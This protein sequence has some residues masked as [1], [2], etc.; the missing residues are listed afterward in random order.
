M[1][2]TDD[3]PLRVVH[4]GDT[5][6][7]RKQLSAATPLAVESVA[8]AQQAVERLESDSVDGVVSEYRLPDT[9]GVS[10]CRT[11]RAAFPDVPFVLFTGA[12]DERLAGEAI[13]AGVDGYVTE[14]RG[15][16]AVV[17][18]LRAALPATDRSPGESER[19]YK[20]LVDASPAPINLFDASGEILYGNDAVLDLL[21][22][23][24]TADL[25]GRSIFEFIA[26]D[27]ETT[28]R[29]ELRQ[30]V[31]E[32]RSVGPTAMR[33]VT[34]DGTERDILVST[35]PGEYG[36]EA[37]GQAVVTDVTELQEVKREL[38]A[39]RQF[40]ESALDALDDV[41]FV[42]DPDGNL[43]R[44]NAR[45]PEV[46]GHSDEELAEIQ[47]GDLLV[48]ADVSQAEESLAQVLE[49]GQDVAEVRL[50]TVE[51]AVIP[52]EVR[53][54]RLRD[55]AGEVVG[56]VGIARDI[57]ERRT[58]E[59]ALER[60]RELLASLNR[61]NETIRDVNAAL[62]TAES[63]AEIERLV[64]EQFVRTGGYRFAWVGGF[65]RGHDRI[66]PREWAGYERGYLD[67]LTISLDDD[68]A[69][70]PIE[71]A[72]R[73][74]T[75]KTAS[76]SDPE[77]GR[78]RDA[79]EVRGYESVTAIPITYREAT[80]GVLVVYSAAED[81]FDGVE[82]TVT[83]ELGRTIGAAINA[84]ERKRALVAD[85]TVELALELHD[86]TEFFSRFAAAVG[87]RIELEKVT[88]LDDG[89]Q[90]LYLT[91]ESDD[92]ARIGKVC[93]RF[94]SVTSWT[95][96]TEGSESCVVEL[97]VV[98]SLVVDLLA[99]HG[100]RLVSLAASPDGCELETELPF[101]TDVRSFL[102][103]LQGEYRK[104]ELVAQRE[105]TERHHPRVGLRLNDVL[106]ARQQEVLETA[107]FAGYY[108]EPR[109]K[110]GIEIAETLDISGPTFHHH[111]RS[112]ERRLFGEL[113]TAATDDTR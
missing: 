42:A 21:G 109:E 45:L 7:L 73:T 6:D 53:S 92:A 49:E 106:T 16:Q 107:F 51:G 103:A 9:D 108:D 38:R 12:G 34:D 67:T 77:F 57:S 113:F 104:V 47:V 79:A 8:T 32:K 81:G 4:V 99:T 52:V 69:Q 62:V 101:G 3:A 22:L 37:I 90:K 56:L 95:V 89:S 29:Q 111:L 96:L 68:S 100:S 41:F 5:A 76:V 15:A 112:A 44:W 46:T 39:E 60:Q 31:E 94:V 86:D 48:D 64:C 28:A 36:G 102:D 26:P 33:L 80:Y 11:I 72:I 58:R 61:T 24:S 54:T 91:V 50:A 19:R 70:G 65:D 2:A 74:R 63:R 43:R 84:A 105:R 23:D 88:A 59:Q 82:S 25:V 20:R 83:E 98:E 85:P 71:R 75:V 35:A 87:S 55:D 30:V 17:D 40:V 14:S 10:L 13:A 110:T 27:D 1:G 78:W 97:R 93:E 66:V 18:R